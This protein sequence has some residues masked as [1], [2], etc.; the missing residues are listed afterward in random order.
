MKNKIKPVNLSCKQ[1]ESALD[2]NGELYT[3]TCGSFAFNLSKEGYD[4]G[5]LCDVHS[6]SLSTKNLS[7][8]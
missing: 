5:E 4:Q 8:E 3:H 2:I 1:R 7:V 6:G